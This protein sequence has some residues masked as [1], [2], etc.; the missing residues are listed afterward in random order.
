M[1]GMLTWELFPPMHLFLGDGE[2]WVQP[3]GLVPPPPGTMLCES[4]AQAT[5]EGSA[6]VPRVAQREGLGEASCKQHLGPFGL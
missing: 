6:S 2:L 3:G 5:V 1:E 4:G